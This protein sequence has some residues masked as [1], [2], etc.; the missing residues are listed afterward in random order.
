LFKYDWTS[1]CDP[2]RCIEVYEKPL[3]ESLRGAQRRDDVATPQFLRN[4]IASSRRGGIRNDRPRHFQRSH[5][6]ALTMITHTA[7]NCS[8]TYLRKEVGKWVDRIG[9][10]V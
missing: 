7:K 10:K 6:K 4:E 2:S 5:I 8:V 9:R 3:F 1:F